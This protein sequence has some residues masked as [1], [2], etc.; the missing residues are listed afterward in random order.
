LVSQ[1]WFDDWDEATCGAEG[2]CD[3]CVPSNPQAAAN[4]EVIGAT[5]SAIEGLERLVRSGS[6]NAAYHACEALSQ[7]AFRNSRNAQ[8]V[9]DCRSPD[10]PTAL[11]A[12][13]GLY[14]C[15]NLPFA[16]MNNPDGQ[17]PPGGS[18]KGPGMP[19]NR[20]VHPAFACLDNDSQYDLQAAVLR[21]L[22]NCA[23]GSPRA[24]CDIVDH[25]DLMNVC[26]LILFSPC[27]FI[28]G[29]LKIFRD[30]TEIVFGVQAIEKVL[31]DAWRDPVLQQ[32]AN[33][34]DLPLNHQYDES[35]DREFQPR[36]PRAARVPTPIPLVMCIDAA[37][38]LLNHLS[39]HQHSKQIILRRRIAEDILLPMVMEADTID[40][41]PEQFLCKFFFPFSVCFLLRSLDCGQFC[42][43]KHPLFPRAHF[44][45]NELFILCNRQVPLP[46]QLRC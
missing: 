8:R 18:L 10:M 30:L 28:M 33:Q 38:G 41:P 19:G 37:V 15:Q 40:C 20:S 2:L 35:Q 21:V 44:L 14:G 3:L 9:M 42:F 17:P 34:P 11:A 29:S 46:E 26:S 45:K 16:A 12:L 43:L 25:D 32:A 1:L 22:N 39:T 4:R 36:P 6:P 24:C 7:I 23:W 31:L 5:P 27:R 13:L